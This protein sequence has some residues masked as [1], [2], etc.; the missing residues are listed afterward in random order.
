MT[1]TISHQYDEILQAALPGLE[2]H[3][4]YNCESEIVFDEN[5]DEESNRLVSIETRVNGV[6]QLLPV[7]LFPFESEGME[8]RE[9]LAK[10]RESARQALWAEALKVAKESPNVWG[11]MAKIAEHWQRTGTTKFPVSIGKPE[12]DF[13]E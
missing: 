4:I 12:K 3:V 11:D 8:A 6:Q 13:V 1:H 9:F 2:V 5:G 7:A 10:L